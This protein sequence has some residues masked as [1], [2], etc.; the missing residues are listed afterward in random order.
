VLGETTWTSLADPPEGA[1]QMESQLVKGRETPV[2]AYRLDPSHACS[3]DPS[4]KGVS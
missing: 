2:V 1:E 3:G 4:N